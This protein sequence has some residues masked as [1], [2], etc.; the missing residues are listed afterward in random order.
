M[1]LFFEIHCSGLQMS[2]QLKSLL[3]YPCQKIHHKFV[4][5]IYEIFLY[6]QIFIE[7]D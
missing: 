3:K 5:V 1:S 2:L 4:M 6:L 7:N